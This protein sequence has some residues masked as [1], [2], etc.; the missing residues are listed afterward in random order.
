MAWDTRWNQ[1]GMNWGISHFRICSQF[2]AQNR[3][4]V[5]VSCKCVF[6]NRIMAEGTLFGESESWWTCKQDIHRSNERGNFFIP[7]LVVV[8][9]RTFNG[10]VAQSLMNPLAY[11]SLFTWACA[12]NCWCWFAHRQSDEFSIPSKKKAFGAAPQHSFASPLQAELPLIEL[13]I[14]TW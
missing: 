10:V 1:F 8:V 5:L 7:D 13:L 14:H 4:L 6:G 12:L 11:C 2:T 9:A 3:F